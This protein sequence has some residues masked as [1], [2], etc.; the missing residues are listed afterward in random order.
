M[1]LFRF[2]GHYSPTPPLTH[3][4]A[5]NSHVSEKHGLGVGWV[6]SFPDT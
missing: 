1:D 4:S 2:L 5:L 6:G 3:V